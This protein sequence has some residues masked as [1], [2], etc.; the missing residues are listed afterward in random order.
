MGWRRRRAVCESWV[1]V[2]CGCCWGP[3][4]YRGF[5]SAWRL[6]LLLAHPESQA[7]PLQA[8][9]FGQ[10]TPA[11]SRRSCSQLGCTAGGGAP[12][13]PR[14]GVRRAAR[15]AWRALPAFALPASP[16][17]DE[18]GTIGHTSA[19]VSP[20]PSRPEGGTRPAPGEAQERAWPKGTWPTGLTG[21]SGTLAGGS[22]RRAARAQRQ[23]PR[24]A[25]WRGRAGGGRSRPGGEGVAGRPVAKR[26]RPP[27]APLTKAAVARAAG[28]GARFLRHQASSFACR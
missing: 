14:A 8:R 27:R 13:V 12:W 6:S 28:A 26:R 3:S 17:L 16:S 20:L 15:A 4:A 10:L 1:W 7:A 11:A 22:H 9:S 21:L 18:V 24:R 19:T 2:S 23:A 5:F 25:A